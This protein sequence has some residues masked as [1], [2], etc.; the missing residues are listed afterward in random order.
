MNGC[1]QTCGKPRRRCCCTRPTY[2]GRFY[3]NQ[4][5]IATSSCEGYQIG[6]SATLSV[7]LDTLWTTDSIYESTKLAKELAQIDAD[8]AIRC[9]DRCYS[10]IC[11]D[12]ELSPGVPAPILVSNFTGITD[13]SQSEVLYTFTLDRNC[14]IDFEVDIIGYDEE[15]ADTVLATLSE[16]N[17]SETILL[18][19]NVII[20]LLYTSDEGEFFLIDSKNSGGRFFV[21]GLPCL[22]ESNNLVLGQASDITLLPAAIGFI[23]V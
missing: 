15:G 10:L 7:P 11:I 5:A 8:R 9:L 16:S 12:A 21:P 2:S 23:P 1:C 14:E 19:G 22:Y 6:A 3:G 4:K 17:L 18:A 20:D 13:F